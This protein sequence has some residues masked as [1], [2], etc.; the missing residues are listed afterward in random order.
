MSSVNVAS[1]Q[2]VTLDVEQINTNTDELEAK[3]DISN[4]HLSAIQA[5]VEI[6]D[7]AVS[8]TELQVDVVTSSLPTGASTEAT[9]ATK[10][11]ES[12]LSTRASEST[13]ST[14]ASETT[15]ATRA[16]ETTLATRASED[17]QDLQIKRAFGGTAASDVYVVK[18]TGAK[19]FTFHGIQVVD[20]ITLTSV[21]DSNL[22]GDSLSGAVLKTGY[23]PI[24]GTAI[25]CSAVGLAY[26]IGA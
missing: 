20:D 16:S 11:S 7:N 12:T 26:L 3:A 21:T 9:L 25:D 15:L 4:T 24:A 6:L 23:H 13:L 8:G 18:S 10:A 1:S 5:A 17:K 14:R 22:A 19:T 2:D